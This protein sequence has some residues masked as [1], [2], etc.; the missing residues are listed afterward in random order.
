M[1]PTLMVNKQNF[2]GDITENDGPMQFIC[3]GFKEMP[4]VC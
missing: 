2:R 1:W 4:D 3:E